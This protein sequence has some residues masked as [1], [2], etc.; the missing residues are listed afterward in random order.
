[1]FKEDIVVSFNNV[2]KSFTL[3]ESYQDELKSYFANLL[4]YLFSKKEYKKKIIL[5]DV[6]FEIKKGEVVGFIGKN[7]TGKTTLLTMLCQITRPQ[8][9]DIKVDGSVAPL[10]GLGS[11]FHHDLS[12]YENIYLNGVILGMSIKEIDEKVEDIID[13]SGIR[14]YI[15][16]PIK[17]YS[18]GMLSRLAFSV[19]IIRDADIIIIDET[20]SV[21][22]KEFSK[23]SFDALQEYK[24]RGKTIILVSHDLG[25]VESFC[26]RLIWL[27]N[28]KIE[29][30]GIPSDVIKQ[31]NEK[32]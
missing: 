15:H 7:G 4:K 17:V 8:S 12:G 16:E 6:S 32:N 1:M 30:D 11:G 23:K 26:N 21:G 19:A 13:F 22:D 29:M 27:N 20:L 5:D 25:T 10:L 14:E 24:K 2:S 3:T 18:S 28:G 9:G 31:Y